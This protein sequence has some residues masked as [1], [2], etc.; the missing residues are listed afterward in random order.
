MHVTGKHILGY[1]LGDFSFVRILVM[2]IDSLICDISS[3]K[4]S[5][6][7]NPWAESCAHDVHPDEYLNRRIRLKQ[8][9]ECTNPSIILIG[10]APGYQGCR[11]TGIPFTSEKL[12]VQRLIPRVSLSHPFR[13]TVRNKPWSEPSATVVWG[14]LHQY[15]IQERT[16]LF[17]AVPW[18]PQ[19]LGGIHSNRTP[20]TAEKD[21]G[22]AFLENLLNLF[23]G[24]RVAAVGNIAHESV[25]SLGISCFK[26]RH[27]A[28]GGAT[29]FR[30]GMANLL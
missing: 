17:N 20:T 26:L 14:A 12:I 30:Q 1:S 10:E 15:S 25:K 29:L 3:V 27:P 16:I 23:Q 18:H 4:L 11:Y 24:V 5:G 13:I 9:L 22:L 21:A 8:H 28:R 19:G 6:M 7:F 2:N